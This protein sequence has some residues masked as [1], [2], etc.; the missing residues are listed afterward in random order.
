MDL[1]H[2]LEKLADRTSGPVFASDDPAAVEEIAPFNTALEQHPAVVV[3]PPT[4]TT[5]AMLS[6][7]PPNRIWRSRLKPPAT[8][9]TTPPTA[10]WL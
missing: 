6:S 1:K 2:G 8:G 5:Y 7:G 10:G 3:A 4:P 9:C